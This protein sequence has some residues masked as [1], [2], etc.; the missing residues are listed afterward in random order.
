[1]NKTENKNL[2]QI[3]IDVQN[4]VDGAFEKLYNET[5]RYSYAA[6]SLLLKNKEDIEDVLQNSYM[7]ASKYLS[8]LRNPES[9]LSW[10]GVIINHECKKHIIHNIKSTDI[11]FAVLGKKEQEYIPEEDIPF[12]LIEQKEISC[13]I[14]A[15]VDKLPEDKR[16]C[17][18]LYYFEQRTLP[19]IA[20][21]L[22]IPEGT[23]KS[24]LY[25]ARKML[26]KRI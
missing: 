21:I 12:D 3:V 15:M 5:I 8:D 18:V 24:R 13:S 4:G 10:L 17:V 11:Y 22:G 2:T 20:D 1:M 19:E 14:Q 26:E 16:A 7:Y 25:N 9:F 6:A 23:V